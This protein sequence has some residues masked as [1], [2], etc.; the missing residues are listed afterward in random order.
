MLPRM[1]LHYKKNEN[2]RNL[3]IIYLCL[4]K[5]KTFKIKYLQ[6]QFTQNIV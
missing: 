3:N 5:K 4:H 1:H 2:I 6:D